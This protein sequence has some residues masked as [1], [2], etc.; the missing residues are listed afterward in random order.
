MKKIELKEFVKRAG[1]DTFMSTIVKLITPNLAKQVL[2]I[3]PSPL[4]SKVHSIFD[5]GDKH[6]HFCIE[7]SFR[8]IPEGLRPTAMDNSGDL[9]FGLFQ[10]NLISNNIREIVIYDSCEEFFLHREFHETL[11]EL[12]NVKIS[13][14]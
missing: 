5:E 2:E 3:A 4:I 8:A 13:K 9:G 14:N 7:F 10:S 1:A 12:C 11:G 6:Y